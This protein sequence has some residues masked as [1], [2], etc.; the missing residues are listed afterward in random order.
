MASYTYFQ[1]NH[2]LSLLFF[3]A[4]P[5]VD[6][7]LGL[8]LDLDLDGPSLSEV[9]PSEDRTTFAGYG[10]VGFPLPRRDGPRDGKRWSISATDRRPSDG[11]LAVEPTNRSN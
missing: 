6:L 9:E 5:L 3:G 1:D 4:E 7:S 8:D 10:G 2:L 11:S